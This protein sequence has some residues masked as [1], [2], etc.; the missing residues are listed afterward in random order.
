M[1]RTSAGSSSARSGSRSS[2][3]FDNAGYV[4]IVRCV[5]PFFAPGGTEPPLV[6]ALPLRDATPLDAS[7]TRASAGRTRPGTRLPRDTLDAVNR[8][9]V[10]PPEIDEV[11]VIL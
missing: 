6:W 2:R 10:T 1:R 4:P 8:R 5:R 11:V 9:R 3:H 7:R